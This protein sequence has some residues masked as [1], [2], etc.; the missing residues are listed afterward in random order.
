MAAG[1]LHVDK[2]SF[3]ITSYCS[4]RIKRAI[5][6]FRP[7]IKF[8]IILKSLNYFMT[9]LQNLSLKKFD[10]FCG[11]LSHFTVAAGVIQVDKNSFK[12]TL[13]CN[14]WIKETMSIFK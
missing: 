13:Y 11:V 14:V 3:K 9:F 4:G 5:N 1:I 12:T 7:K 10:V 8:L 2:N 6:S